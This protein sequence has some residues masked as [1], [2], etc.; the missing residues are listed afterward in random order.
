MGKEGAEVRGVEGPVLEV[1]V[2]EGISCAEFVALEIYW[3]SR[4]LMID[5]KLSASLISGTKVRVGLSISVLQER[6]RTCLLFDRS[7]GHDGLN[8]SFA[9]SI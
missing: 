7:N 6:M 2:R 4:S 1:E 5:R 8:E 3:T 9:Y